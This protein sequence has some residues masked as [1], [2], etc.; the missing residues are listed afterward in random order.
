[1]NIQIIRKKDPKIADLIEKETKR[2]QETLNLV[3][4]E[5]YPSSAVRE[6]LSSMFVVK[7]SEGRPYKRYYGG[8]KNIDKLE[9]LVENRVRKVFRLNKNWAVNVQTYSGSQANYAVLRGILNLGDKIMSLSLPHGGHLSQGT[10]VSLS[11]QDFKVVNYLLNKK[12]FLDYKEI[13][14]LAKKEKPN[15]IIA[16]YSAYPRKIDFKKFGQ[17]ARK[18]GAYFMADIAHISGLV[19][20]RVHPSPFPWADVVTTT[21]HKTLRGPRGAI[22]ICREDL[23]NKIFP[24][25]F[26]GLQGGPHNQTICGLGVAL[27]EAQTKQ[28]KK[29]TQQIIKN[30]KTLAAD[31]RKYGFDLISGGTDNHLI[32]IDLTNKGVSGKETQ[33][34]LEKSGII[35]N[36][37]SIPYDQRK[38]F[39]PSGIRIGTPAITTRGM[40]EKEVKKIASWINE[41]ISS[42][43]SSNKIRK[44]V[45]KLC[46]K[47]PIP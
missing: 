35:V 39:D 21:T 3:A 22:I 29:Y 47:F 31:L 45:K 2:H 44:E 15:L 26:P 19:I 7:Y 28:F 38:P 34:L 37:N 24:K 14:K 8:T 33:D 18:V 1:M 42:K 43:K 5:N 20:G 46:Q 30:A 40:K 27:K 17:I 11:G 4:S 25:V 16:G 9:T 10:K 12:G 32:L 6:A 23:R 41:I 13:E 36:K